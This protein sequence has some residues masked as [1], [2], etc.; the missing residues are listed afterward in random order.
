[1]LSQFISRWFMLVLLAVLAVGNV[2][3]Q[4]VANNVPLN[5]SPFEDDTKTY[6]AQ[7][8]HACHGVLNFPHFADG[9]GWDSNFDLAAPTAGSVAY[10][11][12]WIDTTGSLLCTVN[13][14]S[15]PYDPVVGNG[16]AVALP[17]G[18]TWNVALTNY[19]A[20]GQTGSV[21]VDVWGLSA[22][23]LYAQQ[24]GMVY[25]GVTPG[26]SGG[27][28]I[29]PTG[30]P[31]HRWQIPVL[32]TWVYPAKASQAKPVWLQP[33]TMSTRPH[34]NDTD[35]QRIAF[36]FTN[37]ANI[38]GDT[39]ITQDVTL[40]VHDSNGVLLTKHTFQNVPPN[41]HVAGLL[42]QLFDPSTDPAAADMYPASV[43]ST[44]TVI[45]LQLVFR[46]QQPLTAMA[47]VIN[48][49]AM[50]SPAPIPLK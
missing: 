10:Y 2:S 33:I 16:Q 27:Y 13:I 8:L 14:K 47:I 50:S 19:A 45:D 26:P 1:M 28:L 25:L 36:A 6:A 11:F 40:E 18:F 9:A 29:G 41:G 37:V 17:P 30:Y 24:V 12:K 42:D 44:S 21:W 20:S 34:L 4:A 32:G 49:M 31:V 43:P 38:P 39:P 23:D 7:G 48:G 5:C 46:G 22:A 35:S 3:A 15:G